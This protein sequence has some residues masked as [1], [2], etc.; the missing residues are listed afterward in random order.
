METAQLAPTDM[1]RI[2][3]ILVAAFLSMLCGSASAAEDM[4]AMLEIVGPIGP[5]VADHVVDGIAQA[6]ERDM[7]LVVVRL[8]TPGG[9]DASMRRINAAILASPVPVACWVAPAGARA[10]SAG[11]YIL[12]ACHIAAMAPGTNLGAATPVTLGGEMDDAARAKA[13]N[14]AAAYLRGLAKLRG[15]NAEWTEQAVRE[16][17]SLTADEAVAVKVVDFEARDL[18]GLLEEMHGRTLTIAGT[19][20][21]LSTK[22]LAVERIEPGFRNRVLTVLTTPEVAYLLLLIGLYGIM[23]ELMSPGAV[24]PGVVGGVSLLLG[25]YALNLLPVDYAGVGLVLLGVALMLAEAFVPSFGILG[26][27][28]AVAFALGS[29][30]MF[31]TGVPGYGLPLGLVVGTTISSALLLVLGLAAA[32]RSRRGRPTT[33]GEALV[34]SIGT[35]ERWEGEVGAI[36]LGGEVWN[37]RSP[38]PLVQGAPVRVVGREGLT[39][40]VEP[41][42][43]QR[44]GRP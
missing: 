16:G 2:S 33:G 8:D 26:L 24:F 34:G 13:V 15:R 14:D 23:F 20:R 19:A 3:L 1:S 18:D 9:L 38:Q 43:T 29:L 30:M 6:A 37:A 35:V 36:H 42:E 40:T 31:G 22:G 44:Q 28:G 12:Y 27:G 10:A 17:A 4:A 11:T 7:H 32:I 41:V 39:L 21:T 5:A 25:L